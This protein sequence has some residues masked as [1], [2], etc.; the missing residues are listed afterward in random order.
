MS[1]YNVNN[2]LVEEAKS[3][4]HGL[5]AHQK[6]AEEKLSNLDRQVEDL[7]VAQKKMSEAYTKAETVYTGKESHLS[8][9][10]RKDGTLRAKTERD[11]IAIHG[12]GVVDAERKGLLDDTPVC[13]WQDQLQKI[14][15]M[16]ED[17][18]FFHCFNFCSGSLW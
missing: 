17:T 18:G 3:I 11:S 7:K 16:K 12:Q 14:E 6:N 10:I 15:A 2:S 13:E 9:Y 8:R 5:K 4:L 1:D